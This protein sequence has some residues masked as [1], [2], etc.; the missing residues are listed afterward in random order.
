MLVLSGLLVIGSG[1]MQVL[2]V[3]EDSMFYL[4]YVIYFLGIFAFVFSRILSDKHSR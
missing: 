3:A 4:S 1:F 2:C